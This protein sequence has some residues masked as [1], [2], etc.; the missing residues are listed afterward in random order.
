[1]KKGIKYQN[2]VGSIMKAL[3]Q[4][5][6]IKIN[7]IIKGP[8]G[9]RDIDV[10]VRGNLHNGKKF[11]FIECKDWNKPVGICVLDIVDSKS[12]DLNADEVI[13]FSNS[14]F[15]KEALNKALRLNIKLCSALKNNSSD[16]KIKNI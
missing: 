14:G 7:S 16:V 4:S 12:R 15:T 8:D 3:Y 1:M 6:D 5:A 10:E 11:L 2:L 13:V 9:C